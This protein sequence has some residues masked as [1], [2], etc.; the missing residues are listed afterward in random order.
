M[1]PDRESA[2]RCALAALAIVAAVA[3]TS[4]GGSA[5]DRARSTI[6]T[7]ARVVAAADSLA[8]DV[9]SERIA[10]AESEADLVREERR[11]AKVV[12]AFVSVH[13]V[14]VS[15]DAALDAW[16]AGS[17]EEGTWLSAVSCAL[18]AVLAL[19]EALDEYG[20]PEAVTEPLRMA[21]AVLSQFLGGECRAP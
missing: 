17:A 14:L 3:L 1:T 15:A 18:P 4:C 9:I 2:G 5:M 10:A 6:S 7:S 13:A 12:R 8:A 21:T 16:A 11:A 19:V 20:L